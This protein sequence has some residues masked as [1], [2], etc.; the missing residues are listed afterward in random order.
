MLTRPGS[1]GL[2]R[3]G[4]LLAF[5]LSALPAAAADPFFVQVVE[6]RGRTVTAELVDV[7]GDGRQDLLQVVTFGIPPDERRFVRVHLQNESG[8]IP[9]KPTLEAPLPENSAAYDLAEADDVPGVDLLLLRPRGIGIVGFA[10][11]E[12]GVLVARVSD[13]LLPQDLTIGVSS[14][15]RGLDRLPIATTA[16]GSPPWLIAPGLG[17]TFFMTADGTLKARIM[18]GARA[19]FFVQP[20]GLMLSESD[21]Q[22]FLDAPRIST[23]D[24]DGDG[25]ADIVAS[26]RHQLQVFLQAEDG[27]FDRSPSQVV[28]LGRISFEDHIRGSG[29]VRTAAKDIDGDGLADLI[30]SETVGGVMDAG[31][32]TYIYFNRGKGWNLEKPD[33]AFETPEV[34]GADQLIDID[35]NGTRELM[36]IGIP[37]NVLELIEIFL[38]EAIDANLAVYGL[39]RP[40]IAP[41]KPRGGDAWFDVKLGVPLD[42]ETSRPAGFIPTVEYD[43]NGDGFRDYIS[44]TDGSKIEVYVGD[45]EDGYRRRDARQKIA[46][47][48]QIRPGD[49][50]RDGLTDL[51]MF[52]TRRDNQPVRLLTNAGVLR[53]TVVKPGLSAQP[54]AR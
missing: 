31:Y 34:L 44:S 16:F 45:R 36:R 24:V 27:G 54:D 3:L 4:A 47:E 19:N 32:N 25:R 52:N 18:T 48:G 17:E 13:A 30:L 51:V 1:C 40:A 8:T 22:I 42:F 33:Y 38:Q 20:S 49:I 37:I 41:E 7:D 2:A 43:F 50:N 11:G 23:G 9:P 39:E 29:A 26:Q 15:E 14:D 12:D 6:S 28:T 46:T 35:G 10:R 53:G 5:G 21:I